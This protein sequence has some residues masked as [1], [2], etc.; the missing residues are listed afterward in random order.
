MAFNIDKTINSMISKKS[1]Q[2][3]FNFKFQKSMFNKPMFNN[4]QMFNSRPINTFDKRIF[5]VRPLKNM[6]GD[7]DRDGRKNIMDCNPINFFKQGPGDK[8]QEI[9]YG[10]RL[11][12]G[13][14]NVS[15]EERQRA[16]E[17]LR[18]VRA[19]EERERESFKFGHTTIRPE[20]PKEV[21]ERYKQNA[22]VRK[23]TEKREIERRNR[24]MKKQYVKKYNIRIEPFRMED[25]RYRYSKDMT[26]SRMK[27]EL[28]NDYRRKNISHDT[29]ERAKKYLDTSKDTYEDRKKEQEEQYVSRYEISN[30]RK[31]KAAS[32]LSD[33]LE[34]DYRRNKISY[35]TYEKAK[36]NLELSSDVYINIHREKSIKRQRDKEQKVKE[37]VVSR[38]VEQEEYDDEDVVEEILEEPEETAEET[39]DEQPGLWER[40]KSRFRK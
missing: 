18:K 10:K 28:E 21:F 4:N 34:N 33:E 13:Y 35:D 27:D 5:N 7:W 2:Q 19:E 31:Y 8:G 39:E 26:I 32:K 17:L 16:E 29:Y 40:I 9:L 24:E 6:M 36:K 37:D 23:N 11:Q 12:R 22:L 38:N 25:K 15:F 30:M 1:N 20:T 14:S 3:F